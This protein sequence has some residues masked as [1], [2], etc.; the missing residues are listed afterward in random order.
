MTTSLAPPVSRRSLLGS[1][2]ALVVS[3]ATLPRALAQGA[4]AA[5]A[6]EAKGPP[7]PGSLK[8]FPSLDGWIRIEASGAITV[9]TG[10][11]ELGQGAK[12]ALLQIA[13]EQLAVDMRAITLITSDTRATPNEGF[14]SGSHTMQDSGTAILHAAA[15]TREKLVALAA[16]KLNVAPADLHAAEGAVIAADGR[17]LAYGDLVAG[18]EVGEQPRLLLGAL[19]LWAEQEE[20]HHH[21][22]Q[23]QQHDGAGKK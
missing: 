9:M 15:Q 14:T 19:L 17:K 21:R 4:P 18:L 12:T 23:D 8:D 10:K 5:S 16:G 13:A 11:C 20:I 1:A 22:H 3:F 7:L 6:A 2:G